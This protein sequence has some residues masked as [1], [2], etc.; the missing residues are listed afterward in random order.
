MVASSMKL[1]RLMKVWIFV[2]AIG[3]FSGLVGVVENGWNEGDSI[4]LAF[5]VVLAVCVA[6][7]IRQDSRKFN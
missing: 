6:V 1:T 4:G 5:W 2:L 7:I 3:L